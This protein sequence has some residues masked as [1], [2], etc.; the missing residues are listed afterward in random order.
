MRQTHAMDEGARMTG[1]RPRASLCVALMALALAPLG[2]D[3]DG[4]TAADA[5][6]DVLA[7]TDVRTDT[8][9]ADGSASADGG[10]DTPVDTVTGGDV[11]TDTAVDSPADAGTDVISDVVVPDTG[12]DAAAGGTGQL[13]DLCGDP[14][15][16]TCASGLVCCY[17]CG[18]AGCHNRCTTPCT[19]GPCARG[20][21]LYP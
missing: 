18:I 14:G 20:C 16:P 7:G 3:S 15:Q 5:R 2:C 1:T 17:P 13:G 4:G 11:G 19:S 21:P 9:T 8:G 10:S 6:A 12:T